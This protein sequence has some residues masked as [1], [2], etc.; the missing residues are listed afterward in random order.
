VVYHQRDT[1][2]GGGYERV[3][4]VVMYTVGRLFPIGVV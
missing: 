3:V 2:R 4:I 1:G